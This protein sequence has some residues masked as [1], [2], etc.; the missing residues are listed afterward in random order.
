MHWKAYLVLDCT[1]QTRL[2]L[3]SIT[4]TVEDRQNLLDGQN[5]QMSRIAN[6]D[7]HAAVPRLGRG[8][9]QG[10]RGRRDGAS[11]KSAEHGVGDEDQVLGRRRDERVDG[12]A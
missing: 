3:C 10:A 2:L 1:Q 11:G 7:L 4:A 12:G 6:T 9:G 8:P 5:M